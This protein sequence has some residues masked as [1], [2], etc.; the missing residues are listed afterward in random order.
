MLDSGLRTIL[1]LGPLSLPFW[2][3]LAVAAYLS[4]SLALRIA[5]SSLETRRDV[6]DKISTALFLGFL[7]WKLAPLVSET[8]M[9]LN[10]PLYLLYASGG[11]GA[12]L[13]GAVLALLYF[14]VASRGWWRQSDRLMRFRGAGVFAVVAAFLF[15]G[16]AVVVGIERSGGI[17][18][19][20]DFTLFD[21]DGEE[22]SL[23]EYRGRRVIVNFWATWCPPCRA[24]VPLLARYAE[25]ATS[26]DPLL[27][28][29]NQTAS[30]G[31]RDELRKFV[32]ANGLHYRVFLDPDNSVFHQFGVRG[33]P[34]TLV[35]EPD[36]LISERRVGVVTGA[37]LRHR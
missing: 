34:T 29:V 30:E 15:A 32:E 11:R 5:I 22:G 26:A 4:G 10:R 2:S 16:G 31:S 9:V 17:S 1:S 37:W 21:L 19:E 33:I 20:V 13:L 18:T 14:V 6:A 35:V 25:S 8:K 24:E 23:A 3:I 7:I 28:S 12:V 27:I 36:G